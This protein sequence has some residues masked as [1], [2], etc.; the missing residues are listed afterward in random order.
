MTSLLKKEGTFGLCIQLDFKLPGTKPKEKELLSA[1]DV[2]GL[3]RGET[4]AKEVLV[5]ENDPFDIVKTLV[6]TTSIGP[7]RAEVYSSHP[8]TNFPFLNNVDA[9]QKPTKMF[10][11]REMTSRGHW[12]KLV[13]HLRAVIKF[14]TG[15]NGSRTIP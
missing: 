7:A 13:D 6:R 5:D 14:A 12:T 2:A 1:K 4:V 11:L 9:G 8:F 15:K 10:Q 3:L